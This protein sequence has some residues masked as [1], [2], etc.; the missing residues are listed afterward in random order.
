LQHYRRALVLA[1]QR[2]ASFDAAAAQ[3]RVQQ[4][5]R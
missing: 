5:T 3:A 1:L 4:L 2:T